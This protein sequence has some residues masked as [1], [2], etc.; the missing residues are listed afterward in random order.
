MRSMELKKLKNDLALTCLV[1]T[2]CCPVFLFFCFFLISFIVRFLF[3]H[4][5]TVASDL[6]GALSCKMNLL[7]NSLFLMML[8]YP[9]ANTMVKLSVPSSS[10]TWMFSMAFKRLSSYLPIVSLIMADPLRHL[11]QK[12]SI[13]LASRC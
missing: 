3:T 13:F 8:F 1:T 2:L 12:P 6:T 11:L 9:K 4:S 10:T 5:I 7:V